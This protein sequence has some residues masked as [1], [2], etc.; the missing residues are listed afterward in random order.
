LK[1]SENTLVIFTSDNGGLST[2][3]GSP[4]SNAPLRAGKGWLYEGGIRTAGIMRWPGVIPAGQVSELPVISADYFPTILQAADL[5]SPTDVQLD[6]VSVLEALKGT[7]K[8]STR[9]LFWHYPH[10]GNQGGAPGAA[11][12]SNNWKLIEWFDDDRVEL[13]DL[14]ADPGET[15]NLAA[16]EEARV[17]SMRAVLHDWQKDVGAL[18]STPNPAYDATK[19]NGRR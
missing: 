10:Y 16:S 8:V 15:E 14:A 11:V 17:N 5:S 12:L 9:E 6:G 1:L 7:G 19:P 2:S 4:T 3:E 18:F 13:F